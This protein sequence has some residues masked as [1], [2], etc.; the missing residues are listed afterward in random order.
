MEEQNDIPI[1]WFDILCNYMKKHCIKDYTVLTE[2]KAIP[3]FLL[4]AQT[5]LSISPFIHPCASSHVIKQF[6][7]QYKSFKRIRIIWKIW[8]KNITDHDY[9]NGYLMNY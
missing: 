9:L 1:V 4:A 2:F 6:K 7:R 5:F 3:S 8:D